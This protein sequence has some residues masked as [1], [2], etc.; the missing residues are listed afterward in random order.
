MLTIV[1]ISDVSRIIIFSRYFGC[2]WLN[3]TE[4]DRWHLTF[5]AFVF[6]FN[7]VLNFSIC[8]KY[9]TVIEFV[10][11]TFVHKILTLTAC[12]VLIFLYVFCSWFY[13][14]WSLLSIIGNVSWF[15]FFQLHCSLC[16][17]MF[18]LQKFW[19]SLSATIVPLTRQILLPLSVA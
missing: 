12:L 3:I 16:F 13:F 10:L 17:Q 2:Q 5:I 19:L 9:F 7:W 18:L 4:S 15:K 14:V 11:W 8:S 6:F 1:H